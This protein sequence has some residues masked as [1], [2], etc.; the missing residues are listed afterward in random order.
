M[1]RQ[2][3][4]ATDFVRRHGRVDLLRVGQVQVVH[5]LKLTISMNTFCLR[6]HELIKRKLSLTVLGHHGNCLK[7]CVNNSCSNLHHIF[8][9]YIYLAAKC[10]LLCEL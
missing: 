6:T 4:E 9:A 5:D 7:T 8:N 10:V 3:V 2:L 1:F